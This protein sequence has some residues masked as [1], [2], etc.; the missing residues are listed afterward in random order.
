MALVALLGVAHGD[1]LDDV[2][3]TRRNSIVQAIEKVA[4]VVCSINVVQLEV[5]RQGT[6]YA[7]QF[8]LVELAGS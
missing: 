5:D 8:K 7:I 3:S 6:P 1:A 4:L 2:T